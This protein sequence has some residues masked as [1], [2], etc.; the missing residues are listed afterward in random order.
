MK[1]PKFKIFILADREFSIEESI[2]T[3]P[4]H[5]VTN[6]ALRDASVEAEKKLSAFGVDLSMK[7]ELFDN[8]CAFKENVG[9]D[10]LTKEEKRWVEKEI[11][12]GRRNGLHL[13]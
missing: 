11:V 1:L 8:V 10:Q 3:F 9:L 2:I 6:K 13:R 4:Q 7:K 5:V 12:S